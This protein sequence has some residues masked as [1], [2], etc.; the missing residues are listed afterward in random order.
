ML[1][2]EFFAQ[3]RQYGNRTLT[4]EMLSCVCAE[5]AFSGEMDRRARFVE[6]EQLL[7]REAWMLFVEQFRTHSDDADMG[8]RGEYF[9]KM[10]R[11][12]AMNY[13]YTRNE[14]LYALL[15][16]VAEQMLQAQDGLGRFSTYTVEKEFDG[17]DIWSRK[18]VTLGFLHYLEICRDA[19]LRARIEQA[20]VRH[21][22]YIV[23]KIHGR[24]LVKTSRHWGGINSA[25]ILEPVM[26]MYNLTGKQSYLEFARFI[27]DFLTNSKS[28]IFACALKDQLYPYQYPVVKAYE[29]ISCFEGLLEYYRATGEENAREAVIRFAD[30]VEKTD[31]SIIGCAGCKHELFNHTTAMQTD[32]DYKGIMQETCVSV[33]WMKLCNQLL[34]LT[35]D[36]KYA[37]RIERTV[38]NAL[39]G[40]INEQRRDTPKGNYVFD[41]YS[42]LTLSARGRLVGGYRDIAPGRYY[43]CCVAIGAAG[44]ALP[45]ITA[46]TATKK[47]VAFNYY[48]KGNVSLDGMAFEIDTAYPADGRIVI[49]LTE[50]TTDV[51]ELALRIP[52]FA[53]RGSRLTLNGE[54]LPLERTQGR[55][56]YARIERA[57]QKG[58]RIELILE[59][60]PVVHL[61]VGVEGKPESLDYL[62][63]TYGPLVLA[64]DA[65]IG[66]VGTPVPRTRDVTL[67]RSEDVGVDCVLGAR[68]RLAGQEITMIDYAS[69][70]KT[71]DEQSLTEAWLPTHIQKVKA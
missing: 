22:D 57:W 7:D 71:L 38:Y 35:G 43:G 11:G 42:P 70:G 50:S 44:T 46:L 62:A 33:T 20:L 30:A 34:L 37:D 69:A 65:R 47:G 12:A 4:D 29:M 63:V 28:N 39:Y 24:D 1:T 41:S 61:P 14:G 53:G 59:L 8:W 56:D 27:I 16:E 51:R 66:E 64:R 6:R 17:W 45:L 60:T 32:P 40:A 68:V 13:Q 5:S 54:P 10:M 49:T 55:A 15:T 19:A 2:R 23:E 18:Y 31:I 36:A 26:L 3:N 67:E 9:G 48:E 52:G 25:S 58:D 21:M